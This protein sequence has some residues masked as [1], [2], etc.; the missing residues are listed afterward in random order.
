MSLLVKT[1]WAYKSLLRLRTSFDGRKTAEWQY[2]SRPAA[3][4]CFVK[5][6]CFVVVEALFYNPVVFGEYNFG[7]E[8]L[9]LFKVHQRV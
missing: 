8:S 4:W 9:S 2:C 7:L 3:Y 6:V 1:M 5:R